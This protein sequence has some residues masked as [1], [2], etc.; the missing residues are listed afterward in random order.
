TGSLTRT[1]RN[2]LNKELAS[3]KATIRQVNRDHKVTPWERQ[4]VEKKESRL[5]RM[6][7]TLS[8]NRAVVRTGKPAKPAAKQGGK[9][10]VVIGTTGRV[11]GH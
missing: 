6:I 8:T 5:S 7:K 3:L 10:L 2:T 9:Q 11:K 1:E 4:Q